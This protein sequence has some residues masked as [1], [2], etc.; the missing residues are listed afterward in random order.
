MLATLVLLLLQDDGLHPVP[1]RSK[2]THVQ[3]M[4][5]IVLWHDSEHVRTDA[6]QLEFSYLRYGD[7]VARA[8]EYD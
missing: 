4:T 2:V 3:P 7:V 6:I 8:G 5:G 1:L